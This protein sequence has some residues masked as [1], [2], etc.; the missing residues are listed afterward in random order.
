MRRWNGWGEEGAEPAL[1][2]PVRAYLAEQIGA[3]GAP[4]EATLAEVTA[5]LPATRCCPPGFVDDPELRLRHAH[6]QSFPDWV[7]LRYGAVG[8]VADAVALPAG[9][10]EAAEAL[11]AA[12]RAGAIVIPYGGGT[13]VVGHLQVPDG[14]RPAVNISLSRC[15]TLLWLDEHAWLARL[16]AGATG[17]RLESQLAARG[18]TLGHF[19]QSWQYSTLGG[20]VATR[21]SGQQSLRYDRI[22]QLFHG[23]RL[24]T[25]RG[26]WNVGGYPA[27]AAG[28]DL[29]EC[30]LGSEGRLGLLTEATV[31]VRPLAEREDFHAVFFPEW[32]SGLEAV[33]RITQAGIGL[34]MLRLSDAAETHI[35]LRLA[36]DRKA[37]NWLRRYL[38]LRRLDRSPVLLLIGDTGSERMV[39]RARRDALALARPYGAVHVG[40]ALGRAWSAQRFAGPNLRN[41]LWRTGYGVD[42]VET[43]TAWGRVT[44]LKTAIETAAQQAFAAFG[45]RVHC[46]THLSHVYRQGC[47]L[48]TTFVFRLAGDPELELARWRA[49]KA[50]VSQALQAL[51][52][53]ISHQHGVG[54]D[55]APYLA[56]EKGEIGIGLLRAIARELDPEGRMNP[57]KLFG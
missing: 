13:S 49:F 5:R 16:G 4:R 12:L 29:R 33:R 41:D 15:S 6:G 50:A 36:G 21:S 34:S 42:T 45:E 19:P 10:A 3:A 17:P 27:S 51:G 54:V 18:F 53:T 44:A 9:H 14:D 26:E 35:S 1:P 25:P 37:V 2:E 20:W 47:S 40:R 28:P 46:H 7:A 52:A 39:L 55:H 43:C 23:G 32:E 8:A 22:E 48:Y 31:R 38:G 56:A 11:V 30:V 57:G 24:A